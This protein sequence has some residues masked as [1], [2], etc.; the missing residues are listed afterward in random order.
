ME[1]S[2]S[3]GTGGTVFTGAGVQVYQCLVLRAG[4]KLWREHRIK[5]NRTFKLRE[6]LLTAMRLTGKGPYPGTPAGMLR[7]EEDL[8]CRAQFIRDNLT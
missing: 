8:R 3:Y 2:I 4:I 6:A 5:C 7:A 1:G